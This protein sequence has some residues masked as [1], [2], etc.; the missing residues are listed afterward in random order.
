M[1]LYTL[2]LGASNR[3]VHERFQHS[4]K[5][6]SRYFN[7]VLRMICLLAVDIIKPD[8]PEFLNTPQELQIIRDICLISR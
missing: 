3:E 1:F 6:V 7:E 5:I 8:D 4:G 2:S